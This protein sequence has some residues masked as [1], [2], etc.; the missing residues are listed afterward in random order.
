MK[1]PPL[2]LARLAARRAASTVYGL[3]TLD[4]RGRVADRTAMGALG[5]A[6]GRRLDIREH[7]GLIIVAADQQGV[8]AVTKEGHLRLP[9]VVRQWCGLAAGDRV[10][11][12]AEPD[13]SRLVVHPP[14]ALD[15]M[16]ARAHAAALGGDCT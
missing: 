1:R 8:F 4:S 13:A 10:F 9:A 7:A 15:A 2:P 11:L 16:I 5:W 12:V 3:A 14:A 6:P